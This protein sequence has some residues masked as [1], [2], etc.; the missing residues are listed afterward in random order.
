MNGG[1]RYGDILNEGT[2]KHRNKKHHT[3]TKSY[4]PHN[5]D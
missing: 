1:E 3:N 4:E 2:R 5:H